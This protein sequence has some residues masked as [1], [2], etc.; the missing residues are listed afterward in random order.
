MCFHFAESLQTNQTSKRVP[1][2]ICSVDCLQQ[3]RW[4]SNQSCWV[5]SLNKL[6]VSLI[7]SVWLHVCAPTT[8]CLYQTC[9][10]RVAAGRCES[11]I[12]A[13]VYME[14]APLPVR[15]HG[16]CERRGGSSH[17]SSVEK[18]LCFSFSG[19]DGI[20]IDRACMEAHHHAYMLTC[21]HMLRQAYY[22]TH[23]LK[24]NS[25][26]YQGVPFNNKACPS[27]HYCKH[28]LACS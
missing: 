26:Y 14:E 5:S 11:A 7:A 20:L 1:W 19:K 2:F 12:K 10:S 27:A 4:E 13:D 24:S 17:S 23:T 28:M 18:C 9:P 22:N 21:K 6:T 3:S 15:V 8:K 25:P 16:H